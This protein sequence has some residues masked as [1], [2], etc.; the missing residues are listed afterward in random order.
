MNRTKLVELIRQGETSSVEFKRDDI[1][2]GKLAERMV[3]LLNLQ[4]GYIL[5]GVEDDGSVSGLTRQPSQ[6]E[7]WIMQIARDHIRPEVIPYWDIFE[8]EPGQIVGVI[9]LP[10][11]SSNKPYKAKRRSDWVTL[12]R[13]GT[14][15]RPATREEEERLYQQSGRLR[16]G[17]KPVPGTTWESLDF[18]RLWDY[19]TRLLPGIAPSPEDTEQWQIELQNLELMVASRDQI[20]VTIDGILLFGRNPGRYVTQ[21]GIRAICYLGDG[22]D[23]P[24]RADEYIKGPLV[25]LCDSNGSIIESGVVDSGW[26]FIRRNISPQ[27]WLEGAQRYENWDYPKEVI[28]EVLVNALIHRDYSISGTDVTLSIFSDRLEVESPGGLPN[29]VTVDS[30]KSGMR[31]ARNQILVNAMRDYGYVDARG[32]GIRNKVIPRMLEHNGTVPEFIAEE[33]RFI[34]RLW[35]DTNLRT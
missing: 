35:K 9:T 3:A 34:V 15:T 25:P 22:P 4:G 31:Y 33:N 13:V 16:F 1:S 28:R 24:V 17:M 8:L 19:Y 10:A 6:T 12:V 23:Y 32:M 29:T 7:E 18:R 14:T 21:S 26:D 11:D 27:A 20:A 30:I 5:L 2:P